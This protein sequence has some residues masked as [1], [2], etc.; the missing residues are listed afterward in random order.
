M[1]S[2][3]ATSDFGT[4]EAFAKERPEKW[5]E[6][7]EFGH[8]H[9]YWSCDRM[10][11]DIRQAGSVMSNEVAINPT[12]SLILHDGLLLHLSAART[13]RQ[14]VRQSPREADAQ[15]CD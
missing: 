11:R 5:R 9:R 12:A 4:T 13:S 10:V 3:A 15:G 2:A 1:T 8:S 14:S 7:A 6:P